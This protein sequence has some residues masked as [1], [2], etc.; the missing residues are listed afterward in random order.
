M[1]R[2]PLPLVVL[3]HLHLLLVGLGDAR[4]LLD[5][6]VDA[7]QKGVSCGRHEIG[8]AGKAVQRKQSGG[9]HGGRKADRQADADTQRG[10]K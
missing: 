3:E 2:V 9:K 7:L 10:G 6:P 4:E 8:S 1:C 5:S